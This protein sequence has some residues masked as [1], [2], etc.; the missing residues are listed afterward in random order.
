VI[1]LRSYYTDDLQRFFP[2][3]SELLYTEGIGDGII[4][5][6]KTFYL[7]IY[8]D[9]YGDGY[10]IYGYRYHINTPVFTEKVPFCML[11]QFGKRFTKEDYL[12][13]CR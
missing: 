8:D 7:K 10:V 11:D 9:D 6:F 1:K 2:L 12:C 3:P 13:N 4:L 5:K